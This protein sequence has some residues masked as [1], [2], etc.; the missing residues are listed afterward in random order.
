MLSPLESEALLLSLP[1]LALRSLRAREAYL[2]AVAVAVFLLVWAGPPEDLGVVFRGLDRALLVR[3]GG[4][5][6]VGGV[7]VLGVRGEVDL[8]ARRGHPLHADQD[9]HDFIRVLSGSNGPAWPT[10]VTG[11]RSFMYIACSAVMWFSL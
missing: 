8:R 2:L 7:D 9:P 5:P 11:Y 6:E 3:T 1:L 4:E 10:T